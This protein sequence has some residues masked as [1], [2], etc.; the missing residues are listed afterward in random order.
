MSAADSDFA[1]MQAYIVGRLPDDERRAFEDRLLREPGLVCELEDSLQIREGLQQLRTQG[2]LPGTA[3][4]NRGLRAWIPAL[5]AAAVAG[6][7][8]FLWA[9]REAPALPVLMASPESRSASLLEE[10]PWTFFVTRGDTIPDLKLPSAGLIPI[11]AKPATSRTD[12][13]YRV[14]LVRRDGA[15]S[16]EPVGA[17]AS[18][19]L[20]SDGYLHCFADASRLRAGSYLL[21]VEP[22]SATADPADSTEFAFN[23]IDAGNRSS[24]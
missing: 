21:R 5:A 22:D 13:P 1:T 10:H 16:G 19:K 20:S 12:F 17:L 2:Y 18:M 7:A 24:Q 3:T 15:G 8:L 14:T 9:H 11:L 23:L 6:V 4:R